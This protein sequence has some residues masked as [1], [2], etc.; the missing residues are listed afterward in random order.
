MDSFIN[1]PDIVEWPTEV[2]HWWFYGYRYGK[3]SCGSECEKELILCEVRKIGGGD[4]MATG[5]GQFFFESEVEEPQFI[6][7]TLPEIPNE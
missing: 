6:P 4:L 5:D 7:A 2:G 3:I 1:N